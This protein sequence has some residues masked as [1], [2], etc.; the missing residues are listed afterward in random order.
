MTETLLT[1]VAG[2]PVHEHCERGERPRCR[3]EVTLPD[4]ATEGSEEGQGKP[5]PAQA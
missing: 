3:F 5:H 2:V 4:N 1:E